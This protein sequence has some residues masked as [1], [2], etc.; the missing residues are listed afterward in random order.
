MAMRA[1]DRPVLVRQ[2]PI[3]RVGSMR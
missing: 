3:V 1:F 2:A